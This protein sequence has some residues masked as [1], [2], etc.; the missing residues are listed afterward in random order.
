IDYAGLFPPAKLPLDQAIRNYARYRQ[1]ADAW[2][3]GRFICPAARLSELAP[4][5]EELFPTGPPFVFSALGRGGHSSEEFLEGLQRDLDALPAF[6]QLHGARVVVDAFEVRLPAELVRPNVARHLAVV[7]TSA[8]ELFEA[9]GPP[10]I[11]PYYEASLTAD[12]RE[13]LS[14]VIGS[15]ANDICYSSRGRRY[16]RP[17]GFKLRCRGPE[18]SAF[19]PVGQVAYVI[20]GCQS[21]GLPFKATAGLHHPI[22]HLDAA[23]QTRMHGFV[24]VFGAAVLAHVHRLSEDRIR[25]IIAEE[26]AN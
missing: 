1:D 10:E 11:T 12:W 20:S 9:S 3:L 4:F 22:R 2:M 23:L 21:L 19:P 15:L 17:A 14:V 13:A 25:H 26:E 24:N 16:C 6:R 7:L 5:A 18:P 8:A